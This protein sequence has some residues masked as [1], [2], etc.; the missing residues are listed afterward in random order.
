M[1]TVA[2]NAEV[3]SNSWSLPRTGMRPNHAPSAARMIHAGSCPPF[4]ADQAV[5]G[6]IWA[7]HSHPGARIPGDSPERPNSQPWAVFEKVV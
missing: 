3:V 6:V 7:A 5:P 2:T 4:P 1:S